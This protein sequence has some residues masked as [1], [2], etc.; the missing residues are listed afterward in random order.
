MKEIIFA[1][2]KRA[3]E[4]ALSMNPQHV[5]L[6]DNCTRG[7]T[8]HKW[9]FSDDSV[10]IVYNHGHGNMHGRFAVHFLIKGTAHLVGRDETDLSFYNEKITIV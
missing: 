10:V 3:T 5:V 9:I 4:V 2:E 6:A 1:N 7:T 8:Y